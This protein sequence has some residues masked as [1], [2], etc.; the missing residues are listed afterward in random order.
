MALQIK[1]LGNGQLPNTTQVLYTV[2]ANQQAIIRSITLVNTDAGAIVVNLYAAGRRIMEKDLSIA[3]GAFK[4][5]DHVITLGAGDEIEG[6]AGTAVK[7]DYVISG[8]ETV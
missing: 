3:A 5:I 6:D 1:Q 7:V 4:L 8:V 2:P